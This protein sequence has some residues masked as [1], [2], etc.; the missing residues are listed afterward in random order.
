MT[1]LFIFGFTII[2]NCEK[3]YEETCPPFYGQYFD[4]NGIESLNHHYR[5]TKTSSPP[6]ENNS[7]VF[8]EDYSSL[9]LRYSVSYLSAINQPKKKGFGQLYA[10]SCSSSGMSGSKHQK[11]Q[12]ITVITLNDFNE[13][14]KK[15][16]T[17]NDVMRVGYNETIEDY[18]NARDTS[19]VENTVFSFFLTQPPTIDPKFQVKVIVELNSGEIYSKESTTVIF[20]N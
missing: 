19:N 6:L 3:E 12:N 4:I 9:I 10:L 5:N 18:I 20:K 13:Q 17:I 15:G 7:I 8:F 1:L 11:Y 2:T 16:D 14:Y